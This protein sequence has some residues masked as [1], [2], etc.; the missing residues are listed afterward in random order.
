MQWRCMKRCT[1]WVCFGGVT[2]NDCGSGSFVSRFERVSEKLFAFCSPFLG[3]NG[4]IDG[5]FGVMVSRGLAGRCW[6]ALVG[7]AGGSGVCG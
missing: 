3:L 2:A 6:A 7:W 4:G 5:R 1:R